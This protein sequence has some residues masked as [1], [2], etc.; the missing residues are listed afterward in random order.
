MSET[1]PDRVYPFMG[2]NIGNRFAI[3]LIVA[4]PFALTL[5]AIV[6]LWGMHVSWL[7]IGLLFGFLIM[8][9][10]GITLGYHRMTAHQAFKARTPVKILFLWM[11]A[12]ALQGGPAAWSATHRRHHA[13]SDKPG[14]PHSPLDGF[15]HAHFG[16]LWR[17]NLV[18]RGPAYDRLMA[19]PVIRFF[20]RTQL[21]WYILT[22][23]LP[24][25]IGLAVMGTWG[26]FWQA[27]LWGGA[28]RVFLGH[29]IT[30]SINSVCHTF[31]TRPYD[32]PDVARNNA[33]FGWVGYGEGWHNNHHAFPNSA[34]I[35][36]RWYQ[37]DLGK[38]VL[39][40]L[41]PFR[42]VYD[43]HIPTRAERLAKHQAGRLARAARRAARATGRQERVASRRSKKAP[44]Q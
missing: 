14:D 16:W 30:W 36:H 37:V 41:R 24:G 11:A 17:G 35:G 18:H 34:Y 20:E 6:R 38:Y 7:D 5:F 40:A 31:G 42:L 1:T 19:D 12:H 15:V 26:A 27:V 4:V 43:L 25:F 3:A 39:F 23:L 10:L 13:L 9:G 29:H 22:F 28:V 32:S 44:L 21:L 8:G 2:K 33:L